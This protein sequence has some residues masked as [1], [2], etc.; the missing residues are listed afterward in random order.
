MRPDEHKKLFELEETYWWFVGRRIL[1]RRLLE[2]FLPPA[3]N[4]AILDVGCGTGKNLEL[5]SAFGWTVG[6]EPAGAA[7]ELC[8]TRGLS[9][10]VQADAQK[11]PFADG[12]FDLATAFEVLEHILDD[13]GA[14]A[15]CHRI[16]KPGGMLVL[17][18]PAYM[19][20]WGE[21]DEALDHYRRYSGGQLRRRL[22]EAG[23]APLR[24]GFCITFLFLP[25]L[26]FRWIQR[27]VRWLGLRPAGAPKTAHI[28]MPQPIS[29]FFVWLLKIEAWII[30]YCDFPFGVTILCLAKKRMT[31][32]EERL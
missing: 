12:S 19:F 32:D 6:V 10:L 26:G 29:K 2:G 11:L 31:N 24:L 5:L 13:R 21:H 27:L 3:G 1:I 15:E 30:R 4:H 18:V 9:R 14:I 16:L 17:T 25:I 28:E 23:F 22:A 20:L 8:R 7:L